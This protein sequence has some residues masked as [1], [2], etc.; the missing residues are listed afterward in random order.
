MIFQVDL[1]PWLSNLHNMGMSFNRSVWN[2]LVQCAE[3]FCSVDDYNWDWS[4][5]HVTRLCL[6][7]LLGKQSKAS[8]STLGALVLKVPRVFHLGEWYIEIFVN[9]EMI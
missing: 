2:D 7:T 9:Y 8:E 6:P 3:T 1:L 4:L 5:A